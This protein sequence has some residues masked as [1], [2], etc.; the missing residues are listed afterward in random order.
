MWNH[1][2]FIYLS[3]PENASKT[4]QQFHHVARCAEAATE[5]AGPHA[6]CNKHNPLNQNAHAKS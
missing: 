6:A 1:L 2:T 3:E 4:P 5:A